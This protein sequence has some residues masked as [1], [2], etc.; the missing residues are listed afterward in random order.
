MLKNEPDA[1]VRFIVIQAPPKQETPS[2]LVEL[3][4][5]L[6]QEIRVIV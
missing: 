1:L 4:P 6:M 5:Y 2:T 3:F